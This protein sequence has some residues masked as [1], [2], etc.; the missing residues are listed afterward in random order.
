MFI[1][2]SMN[3]DN[4]LVYSRLNEVFHEWK[5]GHSEVGI[6]YVI[7]GTEKYTLNKKS[8]VVSKGN[9]LLVNRGQAHEVAVA[10]APEPVHGLCMLISGTLLND[11][12][13][14]NTAPGSWLLD[15]PEEK[16]RPEFDFVEGIYRPDDVLN[17]YISSLGKMLN[18]ETGEIPVE[19][20]ELFYGLAQQL[21]ASQSLTGERVQQI[22]ANR[23]STREEL[24]RRI[25]L[26]K[27]IIDD[28]F[29]RELE[30]A[31]LAGTV[32]M[33][34]FHF[35]RTFKQVYGISPHR[36]QVKRRL[37][38]AQKMLGENKLLVTEIAFLCGFAD[39]HSFSKSFKKAFGISPAAFRK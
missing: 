8:Y 23:K 27:Q 21:L 12:L 3:T 4:L 24:Y 30:I 15:N 28:S 9:F 32:A 1:S 36:Y 10:N 26:A 39:I 18:R 14:N 38:N 20:A 7:S 37:E 34:E 17:Q 25:S 35:F 29:N 19:S 13:I 5:S 11:V 22:N 2:N 16:I 33:S 6:K 31:K